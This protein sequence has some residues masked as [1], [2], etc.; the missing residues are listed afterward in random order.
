MKVSWSSFDPSAFSFHHD[1]VLVIDNF[2]TASER[3]AFRSS[4]HQAL[5]QI[6]SRDAACPRRLSQLR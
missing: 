4:M 2:W 6:A 3:K 1:P 5:W